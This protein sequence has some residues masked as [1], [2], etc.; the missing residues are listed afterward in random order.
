[1][2]H[3]LPKC[4]VVISNLVPLSSQ[5]EK[6]HDIWHWSFVN[7]ARAQDVSEVL[8]STYVPVTQDDINLFTEK[9]KF[10]Y[11]VLETKVLTD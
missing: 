11:A 7:Q 9:Q 6:Y 1:M 8:D 3:H 5:F 2:I 10:V 4:F